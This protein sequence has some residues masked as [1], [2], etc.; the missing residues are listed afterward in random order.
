[1]Q[2]LSRVIHADSK[3]KLTDCAAGMVLFSPAK[4]VALRLRIDA[5]IDCQFLDASKKQHNKHPKDKELSIM[6]HVVLSMFVKF[7]GNGADTSK[8]SPD[9]KPDSEQGID[10]SNGGH[11]SLCQSGGHSR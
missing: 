11:C 7:T 9:P 3:T 2:E 8:T 1:M 6:Q 5:E 10:G 4:T